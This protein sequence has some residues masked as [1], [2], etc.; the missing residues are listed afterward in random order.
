[1]KHPITAQRLKEAMNEK[2]MKAVELSARSGV[3]K[4]SISQYMNGSHSMSNKAAGAIGKVLG[5]DP[6]WLMG[7]DVPK[8]AVEKNEQLNYYTD[9]ETAR[10]A[11][12]AFDNPD[13]RVLFDAADG[14]RPEDIQMAAE[15]LKRLK[16]T[17]IEE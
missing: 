11:Q 15:L 14:A 16:G 9:P 7:F 6:V 5:V 3:L 13:L 2:G 17:A 1:M 8:Y 10:K 4:S 12:E